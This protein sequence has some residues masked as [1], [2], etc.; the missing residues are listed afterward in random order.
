MSAGK[1]EVG[2]QL[3]LEGTQQTLQWLQ[4]EL[5]LHS[6]VHS[7]FPPIA[8]EQPSNTHKKNRGVEVMNSE[9]LKL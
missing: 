5:S 8:F 2:K 6:A 9:K 1:R 3:G 7:S 4:H